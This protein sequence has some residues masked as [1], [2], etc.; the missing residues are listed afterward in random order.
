MKLLQKA[1]GT[2]I[3][4][5]VN[6]VHNIQMPELRKIPTLEEIE[7]TPVRCP[8]KETA[9]KM[10]A[11]IQSTRDE[12]DSLGGTIR[13]FVSKLP[14]GLGEPV[15]DKLE[16]DLAKACLSLP[17]CKGF[18]VGSGF[19][20]ATA[21][22]GSEHNDSLTTENGKI[23]TQTNHSG[24]IQGG[25]SNGEPLNLRL[26]FKPTSTIAK[27]QQSVTPDGAPTTLESQGRHDPCVLPRA[28]VIVEAMVA[29]V[30]A[31]HALRHHGQCRFLSST[32]S[33]PEGSPLSVAPSFS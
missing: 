20:G 21:L 6:Q 22:K 2:E 11:L 28:V 8:H 7:A 19:H 25:I 9:L 18:E 10:A 15:F 31:D 30:L 33:Q 17:A 32:L 27:P 26:A 16:A 1:F 12:G 23:H 5:F 29:L 24:G 4:A 13:C 3:S 14:P